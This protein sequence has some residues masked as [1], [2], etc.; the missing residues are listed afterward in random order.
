[1]K[2]TALL[3]AAAFFI[4]AGCRKTPTAPVEEPPP[5]DDPELITS[6]V[7]TLRDSAGNKTTYT[8]N[9]PDGAGGI[10]AFF[11]PGT[12]TASTQSDSVIVLNAGTSYTTQVIFLDASKNPVDTVSNDVKAD[13]S[14]HMIFYN[15]GDNSIVS[16]NPY[17]VKL[18]GSGI[19]VTY[20]DY[21]GGSLPLGLSCTMMTAGPA[22]VRHPLR[23]V[24]R[25]QPG[26]K[27]GS[28]DPG[29]SDMDVTFRV[30]VQ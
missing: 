23:I 19:M 26:V 22:A 8:F 27:N 16:N 15:P 3:A 20:K 30:K 17:T 18:N 4:M 1:M 28:Y 9:D 25:H 29:S 6:L 12:T 21:D 7:L 13:A 11:G 2:T 5:S 14:N 24:L 10:P